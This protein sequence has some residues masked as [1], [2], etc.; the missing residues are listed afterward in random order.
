MKTQ[1]L[2][3]MMQALGAEKHGEWRDVLELC[4]LPRPVPSPNECLV[5][6][7]FA[8]V[9]PVDLQKLG[10]NKGQAVSRDPPMVPGYAGSGIIVERGE[11]VPSEFVTGS[12]VAFL[13]NPTHAQ[14]GAYAEYCAVD[15]RAMAMVHARV[16]LQSAAVVPLA[17]CTAYESLVKLGLGPGTDVSA[18][19]S[20]NKP[21]VLIVGGAGGVGSWA[22]LLL[23]AWH[24]SKIEIIA[25]A[26]SKESKAWCESLDTQQSLCCIGHDDIATLGGGPNGS[27]DYILCLTEP[28]APLFEGLSEAIKPRGC[29]CLVGSGPSLQSLNVGFCFFKSCSLQCETVFSSFRT[30]FAHV[31]PSTEIAAV[32]ALMESGKI[33]TA[34]LSPALAKVECDWTNLRGKEE[35]TVLDLISG[36]H[37]QGK[38]CMAI[39]KEFA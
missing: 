29:I 39:T 19:S 8:D 4:S 20:P 10:Q 15:H 38:L 37:T 24:A 12:R 13:V 33:A 11:S 35:K 22:I 14:K 31:Q 21:K 17:G 1:L 23:Q 16:T 25:T 30:N 5:R 18:L 34:P 6:V 3:I 27:V 26:S 2:S 7:A 32:L 28:K 36:G 9:N